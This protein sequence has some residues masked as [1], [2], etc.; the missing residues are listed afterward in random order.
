MGFFSFSPQ[1]RITQYTYMEEKS[2]AI[3]AESENTEIFAEPS[4]F[5]SGIYFWWCLI[6]V[7]ENTDD[8]QQQTVQRLAA[9][10]M[11]Y[12]RVYATSSGSFL[13]PLFKK[14]YT[15]NLHDSDDQQ[16]A[17]RSPP[18]TASGLKVSKSRMAG[19]E[20]SQIV[21]LSFLCASSSLWMRGKYNN[22]SAI[23]E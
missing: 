20:V 10:R 4:F 9:V 2:T 15:L 17:F 14:C 11:K 19:Q 22:S 23:W 3:F 5:S 16:H 13:N 1:E 7:T 8:K 18:G 21:H 12:D 6:W